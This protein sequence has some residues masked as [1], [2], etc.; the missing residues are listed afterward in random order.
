M[1]GTPPGSRRPSK[2]KGSIERRGPIQAG[3]SRRSVSSMACPRS[4][5]GLR[6]RQ[7]R[8]AGQLVEEEGDGRGRRVVAGEHQRHD[9]VADVALG[10][11]R[12][13]LVGGLE[14]EGEDVLSALAARAAAIDLGEDQGVEAPAGGHHPPPRRPGRAQDLVRVVARPEAERLL[15]LLR[16]VEPARPRPVGVQPEER[17]HRDPQR[18]LAREAVEVERRV[19]PDAIERPTRLGGHDRV[20]GLDALAVEGREHDPAALAVEVAVDGEQPVTQQ[21]DEVAHEPAPPREVGRVRDRHEVVGLGSQSMKI[22]LEWKTRMVN[23]GPKR[24]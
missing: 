6:R 7:A 17:A 4:N 10:E 19:G 13:V 5:D 2:V 16:R 24:S 22:T 1:T 23:T 21:R 14:Q 3:G 18:Q 20:R 11:P 12:T 15:E 8:V 9:L